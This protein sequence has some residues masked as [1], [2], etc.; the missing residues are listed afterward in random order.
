[1]IKYNH[2]TIKNKKELNALLNTKS[3][4]HTMEDMSVYDDAGEKLL[5]RIGV[6]QIYELPYFE[7]YDSLYQWLMS[8]V[9]ED[10]FYFVGRRVIIS[11]ALISTVTGSKGTGDDLQDDMINKTIILETRKELGYTKGPCGM[12]INKLKKYLVVQVV[13]H[14]ITKLNDQESWS[15]VNTMWLH[16]AKNMFEGV[17]YNI[18]WYIIEKIV[19]KAHV[20]GKIN[21]GVIILSL[22]FMKIIVPNGPKEK[23]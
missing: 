19:E 15:Q 12:D 9:H 5:Q 8:R 14:L 1:M 3:N 18:S 23:V 16:I 2:C 22:V 4:K 17:V 20:G 21:F 13:A 11:S 10:F 6:Y 7:K